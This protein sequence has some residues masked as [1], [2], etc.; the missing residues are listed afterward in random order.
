[1][2][3]KHELAK[4]L[5]RSGQ[6]MR[7]SSPFGGLAKGITT[8]LGYRYAMDAADES[9]AIRRQM[10]EALA[11]GDRNAALSF[12]GQSDDED[13]QKVALTAG[14]TGQDNPSA[15]KEYEYYNKLPDEAKKDFLN[16]KRAQQALNL[17]GS[18]GILGSG[19][20]IEQQIPKTLAPENEPENVAA[21]KNAEI[22]AEQGAKSDVA[23]SSTL[24]VLEQLRAY[25]KGSFEMPYADI[26]PV[27]AY[28]RIFGS[29]EQQ[30]KQTNIE[31]LKQARTDLAA[32]LAKELGVNPTDK[33]FQASL[34]RIFDSNASQAS[35]DAQINALEQR[36]LARKMAR[37]QAAPVMPTQPTGATPAAPKFL[38]FE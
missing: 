32:P 25:N 24:P 10:A 8:G 5:I 12:A 16:V 29:S 35:R 14:L 27:R 7:A 28:S 33:D 17:G 34:E 15:V 13:L 1:M 2:A 6:D 3:S 20:Q 38:G 21:R 19:G 30:G 22:T 37:G 18:Y 36:I 31:L 23:A 4:M 9:K 26:A 11:R